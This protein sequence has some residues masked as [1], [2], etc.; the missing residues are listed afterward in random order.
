[1][2]KED[3]NQLVTIQDLTQFEVRIINHIKQIIMSKSNPSSGFLKA[4]EFAKKTGVSYPTIIRR[5][6]NGK[7]K[8]RQ[9]EPNCTWLIHSSELERYNMEAN[10]NSF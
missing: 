6:K 3:L 5:C 9:D 8:A 10:E 4:A 7:L 1:M 2:R